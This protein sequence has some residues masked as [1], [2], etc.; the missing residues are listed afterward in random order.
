MQKVDY[1][2]TWLIFTCLDNSHKTALFRGDRLKVIHIWEQQ[3]NIVIS[4]YNS[5]CTQQRHRLVFLVCCLNEPRCEKTGLRGFRPG[6]TQSGLYS[7]RRQLEAWNLGYR[8]QRD[9][10]IHVAKTKALISFMVSTKLICVFVFAFAKSWF[11]HDEAQIVTR[12]YLITS[13]ISL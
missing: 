8:K 1:L 13:E 12:L 9:C 2:K 7:H 4:T 5:E 10:I 11:S 3:T 6:P